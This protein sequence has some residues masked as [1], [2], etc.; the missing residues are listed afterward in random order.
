M[1]ATSQLRAFS[2][3]KHIDLLTAAS[4][5]SEYL[6]NSN[7]LLFLRN[8]KKSFLNTSRF[9]QYRQLAEIIEVLRYLSM[10]LL[11]H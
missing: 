2:E 5:I 6:V 3:I 11:M 1:A 10:I 8:L 4:G 7:I 9:C